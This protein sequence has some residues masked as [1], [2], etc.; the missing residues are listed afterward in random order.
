MED[1]GVL[2]RSSAL[3]EQEQETSGELEG[4]RAALLKTEKRKR[5]GEDYRYRENKVGNK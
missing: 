5:E 1:P 4:E 3:A 2:M